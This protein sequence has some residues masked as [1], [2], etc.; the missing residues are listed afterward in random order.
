[1]NIKHDV[2]TVSDH[3]ITLSGEDII[4]LIN[5]YIHVELKGAKVP[6]DATVK[7]SVPGGGDYSNQRVDIDKDNNVIV[8]WSDMS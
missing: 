4:E 2:K 3:E 1:M 6:S 7:F 5:L 8:S